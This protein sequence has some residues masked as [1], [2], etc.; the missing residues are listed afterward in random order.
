MT[1][2]FASSSIEVEPRL[3]RGFLGFWNP[4]SLRRERHA[5]DARVEL[6]LWRDSQRRI[7]EWRPATLFLTH[8]GPWSPVDS[9]LV[10]LRENMELTSR[11]ARESLEREGSDE[12]REAWFVGQVERE[13]CRTATDADVRAYRL[14]GRFDLCWRGLARYWRTAPAVN[15]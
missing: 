14:A 6:E 13:L 11:W 12:S 2:S 15:R 10:A 3:V 7:A 9:H 1:V 5:C 4:R 8:F